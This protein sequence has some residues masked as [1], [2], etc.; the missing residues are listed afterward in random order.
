MSSGNTT[1]EYTRR[2]LETDERILRA[3]GLVINATLRRELAIGVREYVALLARTTRGGL[4]ALPDAGVAVM[5]CWVMEASEHVGT[6]K[7]EP[8]AL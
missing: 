4:D 8:C 2:E 5:P 6:E 7:R 1:T 3:E